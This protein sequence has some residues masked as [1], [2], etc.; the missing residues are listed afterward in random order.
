MRSHRLTLMRVLF[1]GTPEVAVPS[2]RA[3]A[4]SEHDLVGVLTRP[5]APVG[6]RRTITPSPVHLEADRLGITA[7]T[8]N[9]PH[10]AET[11][12]ALGSL[13]PDA[14]AVVAYGGLIRSPA[15][16]LPTFGWFN[17]HFSLLPAWRGAAPVQHALMSGEDVTGAS[18]FQ[19]EAGLDTGP[20]LA[21]L[22]ETIKPRDTSG[23][24]LDRLAAA[25]A[26]LLV[27]TLDGLEKGRL[28]PAPQNTEGVTYA[29][30]LDKSTAQVRWFLPAHLLDRQIRGCTPAPGAWTTRQGQRFKLAPVVPRPDAARLAPGQIQADTDVVLVGTGSHPVQLTQVS[31]PGKSSMAAADWARGARLAT[32][33]GFDTAEEHR[34]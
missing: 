13:A 9:S 32:G 14:V 30:K 18:I 10:D 29:P 12:S 19:I 5:P 4:A 25:G 22:T 11:M 34:R 1:A 31:P 2:L 6:R 26:P 21:T 8:S 28:E 3:L 7:L 23:V 17:L 15:L 20:V 24:L 27:A 16:E 33:A